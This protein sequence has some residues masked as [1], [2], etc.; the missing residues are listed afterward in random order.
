MDLYE[1][2]IL[3][4][5]FALKRVAL[6]ADSA[7]LR[8]L[9]DLAEKIDSAPGRDERA[10]RMD[11]F[12]RKLYETGNTPRVVSLVMQL[13]SEVNR[14]ATTA[15]QGAETHRDLLDALS[16]DDPDLAAAWLTAHFRR[17]ANASVRRQPGNPAV[18]SDGSDTSA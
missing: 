8:R 5:S 13:R 10:S 9:G 2:R 12:Y 14:Y 4:E 17:R 6:R 11:E 7:D 15:S 3:V 18:D 16:M 1:I